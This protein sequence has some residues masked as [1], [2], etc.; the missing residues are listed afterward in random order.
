MSNPEELEEILREAI[1]YSDTYN[2]LEF[3]KRKVMLLDTTL[4][5]GEQHSGVSFTTRQRLQIAWMLDYFG[6]DFI[7]ISPIVT[8]SHEETCKTMV[9]AGLRANIIA[10]VRAL[11]E[12]IDVALRC[13]AK[14][15]AVYHSV[16]DLH[17][18][19]K[20]KVSKEEA[21][22]RIVDAV[23]YAKAHGLMLRVTMEDASRAN[24]RFL[25]DVCKAAKEAGVD[26]ISL[27]DTVGVLT[28]RG[29]YNMVRL[30][31]KKV[32]IPVDVHC[33]NDLGLA[34]ANSLAGFEAG[35]S[36]IH[37][38]IN[39]LGE[40]VGIA[41]LAEVTASLTLLYKVKLNVRIEMLKELSELIEQYTGIKTPY[42]KPIVGENAYR[43]KAG[44]HVAAVIRN[45]QAYELMPP[46]LVGNRRKIVFGELS[47]KNG[48]AFLMRILGLEPNGED[49]KMLA[50]GLKNLKKGDLFELDLTE[51]LEREALRVEEEIG[52]DS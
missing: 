23:D 15:I 22:R 5:E 48:A 39:G 51:D 13:D 18:R 24:P 31:L 2:T 44:T 46:K 41:S 26:R 49:A 45:P 6:V 8:E 36:M 1:G 29:M 43:H 25:I 11:K 12:D 52:G 21:K 32:N 50:Q 10:H 30:V 28:P 3:S 20:L 17:L 14:W 27:P 16:S 19:Y 35:A 9:K 42:C 4:R 34:L 38:S 47:G 37:A 40:R 33:H 7:E